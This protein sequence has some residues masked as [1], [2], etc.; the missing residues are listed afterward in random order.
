MRDRFVRPTRVD[1]VFPTLV[2]PRTR[3]AGIAP[4]FSF[5]GLVEA[6]AR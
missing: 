2:A 4:G 3:P 5:S 6:A 1:A